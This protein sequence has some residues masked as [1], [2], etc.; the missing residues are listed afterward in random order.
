MLLVH[1]GGWSEGDKSDMNSFKD[2]LQQD[3]PDGTIVNINYRLA[4]VN[5]SPYPMQIDLIPAHPIWQNAVII[6]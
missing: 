3:V 4:D 2:I 5:R 6:F 1:N